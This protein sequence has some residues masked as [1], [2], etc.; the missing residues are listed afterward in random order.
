MEAQIH[1]IEETQARMATLSQ[2]MARNSTKAGL[3]KATSLASLTEAQAAKP[4]APVPSE[5]QMG[6]S[7]V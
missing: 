1:K 5:S 3:R 4:Y 6:G 7:Q 2:G